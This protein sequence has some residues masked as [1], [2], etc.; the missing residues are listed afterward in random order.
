MFATQTFFALLVRLSVFVVVGVLLV[1]VKVLG[2]WSTFFR[3]Y[4]W[5]VVKSPGDIYFSFRGFFLLYGPQVDS[6][7][8]IFFLFLNIFAC[9]MARGHEEVL[10]S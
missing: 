10:T 5:W 4:P 9:R 8:F 3:I 1:S 7:F 2:F 6:F